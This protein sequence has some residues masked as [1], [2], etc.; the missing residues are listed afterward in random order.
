MSAATSPECAHNKRRRPRAHRSM[1]FKFQFVDKDE[2]LFSR[3][4]VYM[5]H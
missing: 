4:D 3:R 2:R 5:I 1:L